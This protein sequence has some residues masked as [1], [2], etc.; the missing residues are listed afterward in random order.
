MTIVDELLEL[1][2]QTI[3]ALP[4][5]DA[6][7]CVQAVRVNLE[8]PLQVTVAGGVSSGTST[9]VNALLGQK[10]AA[11]DAG[12]CTRVITRFTYDHHERAEVV[13][14]D[15]AVRG[16]A[17]QNGSIPT[18]LGVPPESVREVV[19]HLS[20]RGL[21]HLSIIDTPGLDTVTTENQERTE[22]FLGLGTDGVAA[23]DTATAIGRADA[24]VFLM[25][26]LR[27]ADARILGGFRDLYSG[28]GLSAFNAVAVLSKI[29]QLSRSGDPVA[30]AQPIAERIRVEAR[31]LIS[32]VWPVIGLLAETAA[33]ASLGEQE[34]RALRDLAACGDDLDRED[35][36]MT[37]DAF[38]AHDGADI[39]R[40]TRQQLFELLGLFG[41]GHVLAAID[42]GTTGA[43]ALGRLLATSS[44]F[45]PLRRQV[46]DQLGAR[47]TLLKCHTA[48]CDLRRISYA[49][50]ADGD[51][52]VALHRLRS[53]L[54][55]IE[56]DPTLHD[57]RV[58]D[59][60]QEATTGEFRL[61]DVL[62]ADL[63]RLASNTDPMRRVGAADR[64]EVSAGA[65]AAASRWGSWSNDPRRRPADAQRARA[66]K[67]AYEMIWQAE[68][69]ATR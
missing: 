50:N 39:S 18:E 66:V 59:A 56:F 65:L 3:G 30:A 28:T 62:M 51:E 35:L 54:D 48:L 41:L 37:P 1:C 8:R 19:V 29:D 63:E 10:I 9:L 46:I 25:P 6:R 69:A 33:C 52:Q 4:Q 24:L 14:R 5:G 60:L 49:R 15:G 2:D 38:I 23:R 11:V 58:A 27:E 16:L 36:L 31:G 32:A 44:G 7:A 68:Q 43:V 64:T 47:A 57:L 13:L 55:R 17:L 34:A 45:E 21:E 53:P 61:P 42:D 40:T 12:E 67:T 22:A 26:H 20:N